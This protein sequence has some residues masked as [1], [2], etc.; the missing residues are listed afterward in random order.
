MGDSTRDQPT[1]A[2]GPISDWPMSASTMANFRPDSTALFAATV[3]G[4]PP[5]ETNNHWR[6]LGHAAIVL[7]PVPDG[8][9]QG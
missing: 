9:E 1:Q 8:E 6:I 3:Q 2:G 4:A 5:H 7:H